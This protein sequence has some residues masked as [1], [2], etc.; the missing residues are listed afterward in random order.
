MKNLLILE[1]KDIEEYRN[2]K[3]IIFILIEKKTKIKK[4]KR[5]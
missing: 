2:I 4:K 3:N 5:N 1:F